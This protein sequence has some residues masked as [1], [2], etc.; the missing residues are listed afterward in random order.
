MRADSD[1]KRYRLHGP[2]ESSQ[3]VA[4]VDDPQLFSSLTEPYRSE[5]QVHCY[6]MLGSVEDAEDLVQ[7]TFLRAWKRRA[8]YQ[9]R[10]TVR[11]WLYKIATNACLDTLKSRSRRS[12]PFAVSL[13]SEPTQP[14]APPV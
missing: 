14:L 12:L 8:T 11:A 3:D 4:R 7:E 2:T 1:T 9:G 13:E 6:R 5:L 10:A